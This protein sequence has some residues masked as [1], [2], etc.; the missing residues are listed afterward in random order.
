MFPSK[1]VSA[2]GLHDRKPL[3]VTQRARASAA[4]RLTYTRSP[5]RC[6]NVQLIAFTCTLESLIEDRVMP[7]Y[8]LVELRGLELAVQKVLWRL[9]HASCS[10]GA[11]TRPNAADGAYFGAPT[12]S[13]LEY[14]SR[15][16][17]LLICLSLWHKP[18]TNVIEVNIFLTNFAPSSSLEKSRRRPTRRQHQHYASRSRLSSTCH[19]HGTQDH[20]CRSSHQVEGAILNAPCLGGAKPRAVT[21]VSDQPRSTAT[22]VKERKDRGQVVARQA[23]N[24]VAWREKVAIARCRAGVIAPLYGVRMPNPN[25]PRSVTSIAQYRNTDPLKHQLIIRGLP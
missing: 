12:K 5:R 21:A 9:L 15:V 25:L 14:K 7:S 3:H 23:A 6:N 10:V 22:M 18:K 11:P 19:H 1:V 4:T 13:D 8:S 17:C 20:G 2:P 24:G 16:V